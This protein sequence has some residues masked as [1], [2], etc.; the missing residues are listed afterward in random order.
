VLYIVYSIVFVLYYPLF[1]SE[2]ICRRSR[3]TVF[4]SDWIFIVIRLK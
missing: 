4:A 3:Y 1:V 2:S